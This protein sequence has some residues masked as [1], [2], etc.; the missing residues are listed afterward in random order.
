MLEEGWGEI[1]MTLFFVFFFNFLDLL[2]LLD[3]L[4]KLLWKWVGYSGLALGWSHCVRWGEL[5]CTGSFSSW[6]KA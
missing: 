2:L 4:I 6:P 3:L 5:V 1:V